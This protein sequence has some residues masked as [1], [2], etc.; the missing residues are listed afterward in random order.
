M[1]LYN[2]VSNHKRDGWTHGYDLIILY[3]FIKRE[4]KTSF[5]KALSI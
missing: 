5:D 2:Y 4:T 3:S 1:L